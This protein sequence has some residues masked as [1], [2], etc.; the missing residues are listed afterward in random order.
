M[1]YDM[2]EYSKVPKMKKS[3]SA[4]APREG[5]ERKVEMPRQGCEPYSKDNAAEYKA[6]LD[7]QNRMVRKDKSNHS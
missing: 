1:A 2:Y 3:G 4:L 5:Y 7:A 6:Q